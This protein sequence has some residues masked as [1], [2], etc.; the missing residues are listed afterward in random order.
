MALVRDAAAL[1]HSTPLASRHSSSALPRC[2]KLISTTDVSRH[3]HPQQN[4]IFGDCPPSARGNPLAFAFE[5]LLAH[6]TLPLRIEE[7]AGPPCGHPASNGSCLTACCRLRVHRPAKHSRNAE[8]RGSFFD[9][10]TLRRSNPLTLLRRHTEERVTARSVYRRAR[11]GMSA[12]QYD[13]LQTL[14]LA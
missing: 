4:T 14:S 1:R 7:D 12:R 11:P 8:E 2:F 9:R 3:E 10:H 5:I 13:P 6:A